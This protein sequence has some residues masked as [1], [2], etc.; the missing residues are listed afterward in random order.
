[1]LPSRVV[2]ANPDKV[3]TEVAGSSPTSAPSGF[4]SFGTSAFD[5]AEN[6]APP[7]VEGWGPWFGLRSTELRV[8][9]PF[10][11]QEQQAFEL[12]CVTELQVRPRQTGVLA[13]PGLKR[14]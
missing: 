10:T 5:A 3:I 4:V 7:C 8:I 9:F 2:S 14:S 1:M 12:A 6:C 13:P 11:C